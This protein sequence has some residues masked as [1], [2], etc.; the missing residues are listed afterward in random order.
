M[1]YFLLSF[2]VTTV[3]KLLK[4]SRLDRVSLFYEPLPSVVFSYYFSGCLYWFC[5]FSSLHKFHRCM[6]GETDRTIIAHTAHSCTQCTQNLANNA[7]YYPTS[8]SYWLCLQLW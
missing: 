5:Y 2:L 3:Q 7:D 1:P 4:S 6:N 8:C